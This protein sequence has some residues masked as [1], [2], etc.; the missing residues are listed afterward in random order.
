MYQT[1]RSKVE[2]LLVYIR[3][4]HPDSILPVEAEGQSIFQQILQTSTLEDRSHNA[5][6]CL[7]ALDLTM[8]A[9]VDLE[10]NKVNSTYAGW[11]DRMVVVDVVGRIA[12]YGKPGPAGFR[13]NEVEQW[14]K[15][16]VQLGAAN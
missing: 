15:Q 9:V 16:N 14:L 11:P 8:P 5:Q 12:Y 13:P 3:E 1:Y 10:D 4:A 7:A 6:V 2:F